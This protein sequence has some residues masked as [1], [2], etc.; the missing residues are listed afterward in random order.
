MGGAALDKMGASLQTDMGSTTP[1]LQRRR[2]LSVHLSLPDIQLPEPWSDDV[3]TKIE[4]E[5]GVQLNAEQRVFLQGGFAD[6][7]E[8][9]CRWKEFNDSA[10]KERKWLDDLIEK[11]GETVKALDASGSVGN[12]VLWRAGLSLEDLKS[13]RQHFVDLRKELGRKGRKPNFLLPR[14]LDDLECLFL[15]CGGTLTEVSRPGEDRTRKSPFISF[16]WAVFLQ[17][18]EPMRPASG[19]ALAVAW[20]RMRRKP[21]SSRRPPLRWI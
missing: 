2:K 4:L 20:E 14:I 9:F 5:G 8:S 16:A 15:E 12:T 21:R 17:L 7:W 18:P 6:H 13:L 10:P 19:Q 3:F 1:L 11:L